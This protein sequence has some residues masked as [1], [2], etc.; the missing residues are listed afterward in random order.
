MEL[1]R[2]IH[3]LKSK[4]YG[5][6]ITIGNFDGYHLG[7]QALISTLQIESAYRNL[8]KMVMIFEPQPQEFLHKNLSKL[9]RLSG[10]REKIKYLSL[11]KID[12]ILCV[13]FNKYFSS[14]TAQDFIINILVNKLKIRLICIGD[15]FHFGIKRKGDLSLLKEI[16][17]NT[18][19]EV[20]NIKTFS[21]KGNRISSTAIRNILLNDKIK[22][23]E[24]LLGHS[25][26]ISGRVI[27]GNGLGRILGYP[28]ANISL[29]GRK[30]PLHGVYAVEVYGI[31]NYVSL[32]GIA[33]IGNRPTTITSF[34][35]LL[36][37]HLIDK[38]INLYGCYIEVVVHHKI[39]NEIR[40][41][42]IEYLKKQISIDIKSVRNYFNI[43]RNK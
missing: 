28:T 17:K 10:L 27:R 33:N 22:E 11:A 23:A 35:Q 29:K 31:K 20:I 36:E 34:Y 4:H 5:Y 37:V 21:N 2:G 26:S 15:D 1:I 32:I 39:R 13:T 24:I 14:L 9:V 41:D 18:G 7:H 19:F 3:N 40:F 8:P 6:A 38:C 16:G 43:L 12:A 42:S 25:Y 30:I